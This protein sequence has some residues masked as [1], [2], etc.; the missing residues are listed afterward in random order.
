MT[1]V[2]SGIIMQ[3]FVVTPPVACDTIS[4]ACLSFPIKHLRVS[5]GKY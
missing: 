3:S 2:S 1:E 5:Q 4:T